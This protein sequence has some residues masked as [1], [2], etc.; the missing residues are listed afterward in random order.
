MDT[1]LPTAEAM[2]TD[3]ARIQCSPAIAVL[4]FHLPPLCADLT[5][6]LNKQSSAHAREQ[7]EAL[8]VYCEY[9]YLSRFDVLD[10]KTR[11]LIYECI[12][13]C[14]RAKVKETSPECIHTHRDTIFSTILGCKGAI[15]VYGLARKHEPKQGTWSGDALDKLGRLQNLVNRTCVFPQ[16]DEPRRS[17]SSTPP[18]PNA[19]EPARRRLFEV[20][21]TLAADYPD[22]LGVLSTAFTS[23]K[24]ASDF[25]SPEQAG[26][27]MRQLVEDYMPLL[28]E[29]G[30]EHAR[31]VFT[32]NQFAANESKTSRRNGRALQTHTFDYNGEQVVFW[33]HLR[34]GIKASSRDCWRCYFFHDQ[35]LGKIVIAHCG[36]HLDLR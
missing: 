26:F 10:T 12:A 15:Y 18:T 1:H 7:L 2:M 36:A 35:E 34:I 27:L 30:D 8:A 4:C 28:E 14:C 24:D 29:H 32:D 31:R 20:L 19:S 23:A 13:A 25:R 17:S 11:K 5:A 9:G 6:L 16:D 21:E 33:K 3:S 22:R